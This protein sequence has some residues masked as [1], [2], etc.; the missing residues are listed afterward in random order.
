GAAQM[1]ASIRCGKELC[2][3]VRQ[4]ASYVSTM[5]GTLEQIHTSVR[6]R[7][8]PIHGDLDARQW[9]YDGRRLGLTDFDDFALGEPELDAATFLAELEFEVGPN[10]RI[11]R[12]KDAFLSG[13]EAASYLLNR[14][15]LAAY[16]AH[17]RIYKAL[18]LARALRPDGD[19]QAEMVLSNASKSL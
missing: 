8:R 7:C 16:L 17:K 3:R 4:T 12:L 2:T 9:L 14:H 6:T 5:L 13:Y 18:R 1:A 11:S 15:L 19:A 10:D